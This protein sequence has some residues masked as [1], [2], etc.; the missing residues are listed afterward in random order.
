M[1]SIHDLYTVCMKIFEGVAVPTSWF[2]LPLFMVRAFN[3][4]ISG[5]SAEIR[6]AVKGVILYF[7]LLM[8]FGVIL[9]LLLQIPQSFIPDISTKEILAKSESLSKQEISKFDLIL[10]TSPEVLTYILEC[11][12][13]VVYWAMLILHVLVMIL[14]TA[15]APIIF[16]LACV[17]NI[18]IPIRIFFGL[19]IMSSCWPAMWYGF[20]QAYAF[21]QNIIP[22]EFGQLVLELIITFIKGIGPAAVAYMSLSSG[23]GK[24]IVGAAT[25][26]LGLF[27]GLGAKAGDLALTGGSKAASWGLNKIYKSR[28]EGM[29]GSGGADSGRTSLES[30]EDNEIS[31]TSR[32]SE[33]RTSESPSSQGPSSRA[34]SSFKSSNNSI[35]NGKESSVPNGYH[36]KIAPSPKPNEFSGNFSNKGNSPHV[37]RAN[38]NE[39]T[40]MQLLDS[41]SPTGTGNHRKWS[42]RRPD[43]PPVPATE[44][45]RDEVKALSCEY[46]VQ[47]FDDLLLRISKAGHQKIYAN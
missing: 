13:A 15:M 22:N 35:K 17:L 16:L 24:A 38:Q 3:G 10:K 1:F 20:D 30:S 11:V 40:A 32:F 25:K 43:G 27:T 6:S 12:L 7:V 37:H 36:R 8:S 2:V 31:P 26:G 29:P 45:W 39:K 47:G 9:D 14:M 21:I 19:I 42:E 34:N 41:A 23:P 33:G 4:Q 28:T 44:L 18:G 5:D 46:A